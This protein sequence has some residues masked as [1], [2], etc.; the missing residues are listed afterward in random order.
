MNEP[1]NSPIRAAI[2]VVNMPNLRLS[3]LTKGEIKAKHNSGI[4]VKLPKNQSGKLNELEILVKIGGTA[5]NAV[6]MLAPI[7]IIKRTVKI[8]VRERFLL[9]CKLVSLFYC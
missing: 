5:V 3:R 4:V 6:R 7:N 8:W 9:F 1:I 2:I